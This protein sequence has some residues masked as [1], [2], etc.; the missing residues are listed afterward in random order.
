MNGEHKGKRIGIKILKIF[1]WI[2]FSIVLLLIVIALAIQLPPVQNRIV[3]KAVSFLEEKIGTKVSLDH[4]SISFPKAIVLEGLYLEDQAKDTLLYAGK[5]S[6][7]TDLWAL[8]RRKIEL[9]DIS[10]ENAR[11]YVSRPETDSAYNFSYILKAFAGDST[12]APDTL[13]QAGWKFSIEDINFEKIWSKYHD[14]LTGNI[15]DLKLGELEVSIS[16]F[17][18]DK[19]KIVVDEIALSNTFASVLQKKMPEVTEEVAEEKQPFTYDVG[20]ATVSIKNVHGSFIQQALGQNIRMDIGESKLKTDKIDLK[21]HAIDM[22]SFTLHD[23]FLSYQQRPVSVK[24]I[25]KQNDPEP[26]SEKKAEA[27]AV[28]KISLN[29]LDLEGNSVQF[30]DFT[31]P[32]TKGAVD[33]DHLWLT[34]LN[35]KAEDLSMAGMQ[36]SCNLKNLSFMEKSGFSIQSFKA[37]LDIKENSADIDKLELITGNSRISF[38]GRATFVSLAKIAQTLPQTKFTADLNNT[39]IGL[40]DILYF[41]PSLRDSLPLSLPSNTK[42]TI[43]ANVNGSVGNMKINHLTF[44][45]FADTYLKTNG[46]IRGLPDAEKLTMDIYLDKFYTTKN[47]IESILPDTLLP[48]SLE[49]PQWINVHGAYTGSLKKSAFKTQLTSNVGAIN[50]KGKINLDSASTTRGYDA[51]LSVEDLNIGKVLMKQKTIGKLNMEGSVTANGLTPDEM[52]GLIKLQVKNFEF[53]GYRY[54]NFVVDGKILNNVYSG[55]ATLQDKNLDFKINGKLNFSDEVPMY[56]LTFDLKNADF[57]ALHLTERPLKARGI[58]STEMATSDFKVLNG[59]LALR[60]VA[61]FNGDALY[62]VDSLLFASLD[63]EGRSELKVESDLFN[64]K[65][66]GTFNIFSMPDVLKEF[67]STYYTLHDTALV[68][69]K[70]APPQNFSFELK[71]KKTELLTDILLPQLESFVPGEITGDFD[72]EAKQLDIN[73]NIDDIKYSSVG[74]KSFSLKTNSDAQKL[75]YNISIDQILVDSL[76]IDGLEFNGTVANNAINT[77]LVI[78][79]SAGQDKYILGAIFRSL[80]NEYELKLLPNQ[81]RLNYADWTVPQENYIRFGGKKLMAHDLVLANGREKIIIDSKDDAASTLLIG[82]RELNL[83]YLVS[84][85]SKEKAV[86]GLLQGDILLVPDTANMTFTAKLGI[87]DFNISEIPWGDI[88]L[89]VS[90]KTSD[91]FDIDFGLTSDKNKISAKGYYVTAEKPEINVTTTISRFDVATAEPLTMGQLKEMQGLLTGKI[92]VQGSPDKPAIHGDINLHDIQ[93]FST[94]LKSP[95]TIKNETIALTNEGIRFDTFEFLDSRKNSATIDGL[96]ATTDYKKFGFNL[97]LLTRNFRLLNTNEKDNDL[98]YGKVDINATV[99]I[100]GSMTE[101]I[102]DARLGLADGSSLTYIVPHNDVNVME[103]NGI[104]R[105]VDKTFKDDPFMKAINPADTMKSTFTGLNLT[106]EIDLTDKATFKVVIDPTTGD[107]LVVKGN[108]TLTLAMDPTGDLDLSGRYEISEGTYNLSFYKFLKREFKIAKGSTMTWA[109]DPLN[110]Q[111]DIAAIYEVETAPVDLMSAQL[112]GSD[113]TELNKYK[114]RLPFEVYLNIKGEL[115]KPDISFKIDMAEDQRNYMGGNV[116][117]RIQDINTREADLNKQVFALLILK[118]FISENPFESQGGGGLESTAR[119]SVS[120]ILT[121][122]LNRLSENVKG[123]ELSFD[124]KSYEDYSSGQAKGN[125]QLQ[126]GLS[127]NLFNDR[128]VVKVAGNVDVEGDNST[129]EVTDFI[130]DL[131]LEYKLTE[132]G[133]FRITGFRNSNYDMIDGELTDTGA[134]L[135]YVKDYNLLSELFKANAKDKQK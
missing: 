95:F 99:K 58:L 107:Q 80:E 91:R 94:Y 37:G 116:Y 83:E 47:D 56:Q 125:T 98:F 26:A 61:V 134:G 81:V 97:N 23:S 109:G 6:V 82:F 69:K 117:S 1:G 71:L 133:R 104:V 15:I 49:L 86:S 34:N 52:N 20:V 17:D 79:D 16:E 131:A 40:R 32:Q 88:S 65:F 66:A 14:N 135:I 9:N 132:D 105:F 5:L 129:R 122:Q 57:K 78:L 3:Q 60:K 64:G 28:W 35:T 25:A 96:I 114:Q 36:I 29:S 24:Q 84:M 7:D 85:V 74:V 22:K 101:P 42:V 68:A 77:D 93:F 115:L 13:E 106:A 112:Q 31:K 63:Q 44:Q 10:L 70:D 53:Q 113:E 123:V 124:V 89:D 90:R 41:N 62:A 21:L 110:A 39:S 55:I 2:I 118:R 76:K 54:E 4:I 87:H 100:R 12:A 8:T 30:Y 128:L 50:A 75:N 111:M 102:V 38:D 27:D 59:N 92:Q 130:G 51:Q 19:M 108:T 72:S 67:F 18:L 127:K 46:T 126:L 11:A 103:G 119:S 48:D 73:F 120:K 121:D 43:D 33:F 45:A